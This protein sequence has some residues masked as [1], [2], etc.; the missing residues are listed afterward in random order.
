[1]FV[2]VNCK[3]CKRRKAVELDHCVGR[4]PVKSSVPGFSVTMIKDFKEGKLLFAPHAGGSV[5]W[6]CKF[7]S[8]SSLRAGKAPA[9]AHDRGRVPEHSI[10]TYDDLELGVE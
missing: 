8:V 3:F 9:L 7:D 5:P 4:V 2:Q 10:S 6:S 1:M